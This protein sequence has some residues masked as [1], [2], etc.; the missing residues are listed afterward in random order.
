[1]I[2]NYERY[3]GFINS[4]QNIQKATKTLDHVQVTVNDA[5]CRLSRILAKHVFH[6][7]Y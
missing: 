2:L 3:I 6:T 5:A 7:H 1:M 4:C